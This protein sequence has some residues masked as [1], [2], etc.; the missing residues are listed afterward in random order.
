MASQS[1][2]PRRARGG[3]ADD[4]AVLK[5]VARLTERDRYLVRTVAEHRVLTTDQLAALAFDNIITARHRLDALARLGA[6]N[7][8]RPNRATGSAPWHY[9]LGPLGAVLL[10]AEDR[11]DRKWLPQARAGRQVALQRSQRLAHMIGTNW[12]FA[13][14]AAHARPRRLCGFAQLA[15][16]HRRYRSARELPGRAGLDADPW[17][18]PPGPAHRSGRE[19]FRGRTVRLRRG[20][21]PLARSC[22]SCA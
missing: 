1:P 21:V 2:V 14:L 10:G 18:I 11:D 13:A 20:P 16:R 22:R 5:A 17:P 8:F 4:Q 15:H 6:L 3:A 19:S 7:R 9:Q 12:F